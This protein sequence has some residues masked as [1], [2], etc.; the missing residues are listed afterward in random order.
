MGPQ[1]KYLDHA[2]GNPLQLGGY[3]SLCGHDRGHELKPSLQ[4]AAEYYSS[5]CKGTGEKRSSDQD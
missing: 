4:S 2:L 1:S 5:R 3:V